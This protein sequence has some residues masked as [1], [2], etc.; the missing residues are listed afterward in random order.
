M[1]EDTDCKFKFHIIILFPLLCVGVLRGCREWR[2]S[3]LFLSFDDA[4]VGRM[5][6]CAEYAEY[7]CIYE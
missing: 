3:D 6:G 2:L 1:S 7:M 5:C 4:K